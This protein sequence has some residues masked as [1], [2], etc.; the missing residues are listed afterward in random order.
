[1]HEQHLVQHLL[2]E[3]LRRLPPGARAARLTAALSPD[4]HMDATSLRLHFE[5]L[6]AD[7]PLADAEL[8]IQPAPSRLHCPACDKLVERRAGDFN[9]PLCGQPAR[10]APFASGLTLVDVAAR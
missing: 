7:T 4:A 2:D 5:A 6:A 1:M 3:A 8:L 9:C 10:P